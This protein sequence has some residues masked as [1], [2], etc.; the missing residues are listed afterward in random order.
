MEGEHPRSQLKESL[1]A[2]APTWAPFQGMQQSEAKELASF[3]YCQGLFLSISSC[4]IECPLGTC[5]CCFAWCPGNGTYP[6]RDWE[7]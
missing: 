4:Q 7:C 5:G 2:Q 1:K 3:A 6:C